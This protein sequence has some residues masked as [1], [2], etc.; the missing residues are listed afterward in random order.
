[1]HDEQTKL[2]ELSYEKKI[3]KKFTISMLFLIY[4]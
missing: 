2:L 1:M 4:I 3:I